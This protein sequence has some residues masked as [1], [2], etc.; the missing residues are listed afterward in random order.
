MVAYRRLLVV[1]AP[2]LLTF[3]LLADTA[4]VRHNALL[5][6]GPKSSTPSLA[7]L[8][9][10]QEVEVL[11]PTPKDGFLNVETEDGTQG[12]VFAKFLHA[13]PPAEELLPEAAAAS[14]KPETAVSESWDKPKPVS[15]NFKV[16]GKT[17]GPDGSGDKRDKGTNVRKDRTDLPTSYHLI[18]WKALATVPTLKG[19]PKSRENFDAD[20]LAAIAKFEGAAVQAVGYIVAIKPQKGNSESCNCAMTSDAATD[21]H[22]ALVEHP[23]DAEASSVVVEPTPRIKKNHPN[24]TKK[25]LEPWLN[26]DIPV[27]ISGW[28]LFDPQHTNH[29]KKYRSTLWEIHPIT[30]IE[31]WDADTNAWVNADKLPLPEKAAE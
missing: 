27:R 8:E 19:A 2:L 3:S 14:G 23:G 29:L 20:Q 11:D 28:L 31:V 1:L 6:K 7:K 4:V 5:H 9:P 15:G 22:I 17:C 13:E 26:E 21:W 18:T 10:P 12:W 30:L 16:D 25:N 24:W